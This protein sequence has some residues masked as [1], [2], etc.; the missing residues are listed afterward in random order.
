M[1]AIFLI[2]SI[3][4]T[5]NITFSQDKNYDGTIEL[6][7]NFKTDIDGDGIVDA[8][9]I[10]K[11]FSLL[12]HS[13]DYFNPENFLQFWKS[14]EGAFG[15]CW[16]GA[17][18]NFDNDTLLDLAGYTFSPNKFYVWEQVAGHPDSFALVFE[19]EKTD[20]GGFGPITFGD[21]DGD[22]KTEIILADLSTMTRIF[23]FENDGDNIYVNQNTQ[24][25]LIH[26]NDGETGRSLYIT[27]MNKNGKKEIVCSRGNTSGGMIRIWEHSGNIGS[28]QYSSLYTYTTPTYIFGQGGAGDSDNDG[29]DEI[30]LTYGGIPAYNTYIRRITYDSVSN[31]FSHQMF[32]SSAIGFASSFRVSDVNNDGIKELVMTGNS[33]GKTSVYIFKSIG[34]NIYQTLDSIFEYSDDNNLLTQDIKILNGHIYPSILTGSYNGKIYVYQYNGIEYTKIFEKLDYPGSAIRRVYWTILENTDSY[35]NTWSSSSSNG[36]FYL[37]KRQVQTGISCLPFYPNKFELSQNYPNPFNSET[38]IRVS[39]PENGNIIL[40][41]FDITGRKVAVLLNEYKTAGIY[42]IKFNGENLSGGVYFY[43]L[44]SGNYSETKRMILLK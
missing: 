20:A 28:H 43:K 3:I 14:P 27:D 13:L 31:S 16:D 36:Y 4:F 25:T 32:T 24:T 21:T 6:E 30:F 18:G 8:L 42:E 34:I 19:Y 1:K 10:Y 40:K 33:N 26:T 29:F 23:I 39:I 7:H 17:A 35:F 37:F 2:I 15:N 12:Y 22:G 5:L 9:C 11:K 38:K 41:I 44:Q